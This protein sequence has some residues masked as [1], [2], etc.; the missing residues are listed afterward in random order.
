MHAA[1]IENS[2]RLTR[3]LTLLSAHPEGV[4]GLDISIRCNVLNPATYVSELRANGYDIRAAYMGQNDNK[5]RIYSYR[6]LGRKTE[7]TG[8]LFS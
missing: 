6:L 4:T 8:E 5:R 2:E 1:R 3:I 7:L